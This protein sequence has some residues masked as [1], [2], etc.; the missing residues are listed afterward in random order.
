[1]KLRIGGLLLIAAT[2][3]VL[4]GSSQKTAA[5]EII[6]ENLFQNPG[7]ESGYFNQDNIP[8]IAVPNGWRMHWLDNVPFEGTEGLPA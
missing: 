2:F 5:Q 4:L 7:W 1:M 6:S 8:Q 3:V